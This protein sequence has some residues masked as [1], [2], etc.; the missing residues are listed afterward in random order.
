MKLYELTNEYEHLFETLNN[1]DDIT[2]DVIENTLIPLKQDIKSKSINVASYIMNL[3]YE[4]NAM[5]DYIEKMENKRKSRQKKIDAI[6]NY[7]RMNMEKTGIN[8]IESPEF[9]ISLGSEDTKTVIYDSSILPIKFC[10]RVEK[11][12]PDKNL[13]KHAI[14]NGNIIDGAR[15]IKTRR[16]TIK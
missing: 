15:L 4:I 12:E 13:I 10:R 2:N 5:D 1:I 7:L 6:K 14:E 16:L 8:K 3:E 11:F 9:T